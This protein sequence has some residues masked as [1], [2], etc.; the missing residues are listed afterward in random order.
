MEDILKFHISNLLINI[1]IREKQ[2]ESPKFFSFMFISAE[3]T[4]NN[5]IRSEWNII[6]KS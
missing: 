1:T 2:T 3:H 5:K 4:T 6:M